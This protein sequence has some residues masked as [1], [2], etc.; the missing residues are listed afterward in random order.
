MARWAYL[1]KPSKEDVFSLI[2]PSQSQS[3]TAPER[4]ANSVAQ[5]L[6]ILANTE[7]LKAYEVIL[8]NV[9]LAAAYLSIMSL[10]CYISYTT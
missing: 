10:V 7:K 5:S 9:Q 4:V 8:S 1:S 2:P 6:R 3:L